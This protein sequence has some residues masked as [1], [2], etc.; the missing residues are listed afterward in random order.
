MV[1]CHDILGNT[2]TSSTTPCMY[3]V[4]ETDGLS[5]FSEWIVGVDYM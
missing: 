1:I 4:F 2:V 5:Q 3:T